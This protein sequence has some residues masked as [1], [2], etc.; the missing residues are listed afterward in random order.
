MG[1]Y[2]GLVVE[3]IYQTYADIL[4]S[5]SAPSTVAVLSRAT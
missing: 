1:Y 4:A 3:G 2:Y 5:P